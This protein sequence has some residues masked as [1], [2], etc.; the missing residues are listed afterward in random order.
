MKPRRLLALALPALC[1]G[2]A[3]PED[4]DPM[5]RN[6]L[7]P[8]QPPFALATINR[9][10]GRAVFQDDNDGC[11]WQ[12]KTCA[13]KAYV[14]PGDTVII[15]RVRNGY[16]CAFYP[17]KGGGTAGWLAT[18]QINLTP[19]DTR[20]SPDRWLGTWSSEGNPRVTITQNLGTLYA[21]GEAY[22]PGPQ[23][24]HDYPSIHVG[25]I[26]GPV[27]ISGHTGVYGEDDNLCEVRFTLLGDYLLA[28]D[29]SNCGG[30]NVSFS[31][32]YQRAK[33]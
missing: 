22:W 7:F 30:A 19:V 33:P 32:V 8:S 23:G 21:K 31:A 28:S 1:L 13:T 6:G 14:V 15:N 27:E 2:A 18:R 20:P 9:T 26:D 16:A 11:P 4:F 12:G 17:S 24:T 5:C 25:E 29:N 3:P 10:D